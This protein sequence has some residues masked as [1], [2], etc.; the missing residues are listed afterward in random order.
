MYFET[1][2]IL[3]RV[4]LQIGANYCHNLNY[5]SFHLLLLIVVILY[6]SLNTPSISSKAT[7]SV[8]LSPP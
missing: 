8:L 5:V 2:L 3:I 6:D 4:D 7:K 1:S